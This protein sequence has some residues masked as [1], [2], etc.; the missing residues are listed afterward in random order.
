MVQLQTQTWASYVPNFYLI[1]VY[2]V[3]HVVFV[4]ICV[5]SLVAGPSSSGLAAA[6]Y[7]ASSAKSARPWDFG[8]TVALLLYEHFIFGMGFICLVLVNRTDPGVVPETWPWNPHA[9]PCDGGRQL[10]VKPDFFGV[11]KKHGKHRGW[12]SSDAREGFGARFSCL[13]WA[14]GGCECSGV[15][16]TML[17]YGLEFAA[18]HRSVPLCAALCRSVTLCTVLRRTA[19]HCTTLPY[20]TLLYSTL[21]YFT[22]LYS[23]LLYSPQL[24]EPLLYAARDSLGPC[25]IRP[26]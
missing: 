9:L 12:S 7:V 20:S 19:L 10:I 5:P 21:L 24:Q 11:E 2:S 18:L 13:N 17:C 8:G 22:L 23:T 15:L 14:C 26:C 3:M 1:F 6:N 16:C 4:G 25:T